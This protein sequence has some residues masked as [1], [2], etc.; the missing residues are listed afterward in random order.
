MTNSRP[1]CEIAKEIKK[2]WTKPY[3]G[4]VPYLNAM[5]TLN[6]VTDSYGLDSAKSIIA[7]FLGNAS[8]W[9]G[10]KARELKK[11]LNKLIK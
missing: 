11:E 1:I 4:A 10:E 7:Y 2:D 8:T 6:K 3:F 9:K 5:L